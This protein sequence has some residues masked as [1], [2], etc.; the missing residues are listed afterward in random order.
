MNKTKIAFLAIIFAIPTATLSMRQNNPNKDLLQAVTNGVPHKVL[1]ILQNGANPNCIDE[2]G[3]SPLFNATFFGYFEVV[4]ILLAHGANPNFINPNKESPLETARLYSETE[5]YKKIEQE[6]LR[7]IDGEK[8]TEHL[9]TIE[10]MEAQQNTETTENQEVKLIKDI[11]KSTPNVSYEALE[12]MEFKPEDI[13]KA[14]ETNSS[15]QNNIEVIDLTR[16]S[17]F[18]DFDWSSN[19]NN[20]DAFSLS[21]QEIE[22]LLILIKD[23][24]FKGEHVELLYSLVYKLQQQYQTK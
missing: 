11:I 9:P 20:S 22:F 21:K 17:H 18:E 3:N 2:N 16:E 6:L 24:N 23:A 4:K 13:K 5:S 19:E 7:Y 15:I 10:T 14:L 1:Y 8:K 12:S